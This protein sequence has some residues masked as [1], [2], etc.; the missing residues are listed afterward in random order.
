MSPSGHLASAIFN[1]VMMPPIKPRTL[2]R[3]QLFVLD[4]LFAGQ[5]GNLEGK[6]MQNL[7]PLSWW[8]GVGWVGLT[9]GGLMNV[10]I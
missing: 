3:T 1:R 10:W 7:V 6:T 8:I 9:L 4:S 2:M 5:R